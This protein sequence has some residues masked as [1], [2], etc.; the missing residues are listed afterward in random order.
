MGVKGHRGLCRPS[1]SFSDS[2]FKCPHLPLIYFFL[3]SCHLFPTGGRFFPSL[4]PVPFTLRLSICKH[5]HTYYV[6][7]ITH[8]QTLQNHIKTLIRNTCPGWN[9]LRSSNEYKKKNLNIMFSIMS[10][11]KLMNSNSNKGKMSQFSFLNLAN[12]WETK[13]NPSHLNFSSQRVRRISRITGN[14]MLN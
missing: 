13:I 3:I 4:S 14:Y 7:T 8:S 2:Q 5:L 6:S 11:E 1:H 12:S 10:T 9:F